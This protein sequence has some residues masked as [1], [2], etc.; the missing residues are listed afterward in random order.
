M[1]ISEGKACSKETTTLLRI[2]GSGA[3]FIR[4]TRK[5]KQRFGNWIYFYPQ[6]REGRPIALSP[7]ERAKFKLT[8]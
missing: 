1:A 2:T 3:L 7:L 5:M 6:V 8:V 4:N